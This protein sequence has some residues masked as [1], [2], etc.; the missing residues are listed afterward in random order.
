M[1]RVKITKNFIFRWH[2]C[3]LSKEETAKLCARSVKTITEWDKGK[4]I[5]AECITLMKMASGQLEHD[6]S[7]QWAGWRLAGEYLIAPSG[8]RFTGKWL[9][10]LDYEMQLKEQEKLR[11]D[12]KWIRK[13]IYII[14][15]SSGEQKEIIQRIIKG[16]G[17]N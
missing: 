6:L 14:Q 16:M 10:E 15:K 8:R 11:R 9:R 1:K 2:E 4:K 17:I 12:E 13:I 5:P 7:P 3:G